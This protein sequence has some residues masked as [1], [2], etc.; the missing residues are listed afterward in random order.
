VT[1]NEI[2][3]LIVGIAIGS[4]LMNALHT[5]WSW[6]DAERA[7]RRSRAESEAAVARATAAREEATEQLRQ[8]QRSR[9]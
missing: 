7:A 5:F 3:M 8:L 9:T 6:R 4:Q 1:P 2:Q